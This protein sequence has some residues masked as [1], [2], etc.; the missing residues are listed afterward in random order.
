MLSTVMSDPQ[1]WN[2]YS[3]ALN[4]P[5]RY[6]DPS[7][8]CWVAAP[9]GVGSYDGQNQ[10]PPGQTCADAVA[11]NNGKGV[12]VYG[13]NGASDITKYAAN[14]SN[15]VNVGALS[16]HHDANFESVQTPGREENYL[17]SSQAA[18]LFNVAF[19][20]QPVVKVEKHLLSM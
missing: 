3:Y 4:N 19:A 1:S 14:G 11:T 20:Y 18:A 8:E 13:S 16:G 10:A 9:S 12:T 5:L 17:G 15:V 2:R 6:I 7:G